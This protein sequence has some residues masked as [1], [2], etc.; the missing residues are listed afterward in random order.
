[1]NTK[2]GWANQG[3]NMFEDEPADTLVPRLMAAGADLKFVF[4]VDKTPD[5]DVSVALIPQPICSL[6]WRL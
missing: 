4:F 2:A 1:M 3:K 6:C 5:Q